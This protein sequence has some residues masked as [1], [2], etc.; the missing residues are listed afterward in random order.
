MKAYGNSKLTRR[1]MLKMLGMTAGGAAL[2]SCVPAPVP[3]ETAAE[4]AA[5]APTEVA[6]TQAPA[7]EPVTLSL[8]FGDYPEE[9]F[10]EAFDLFESQTS[11]KLDW[12]DVPE[13]WVKVPAA[14]AAGELPDIIPMGDTD[15]STLSVKNVLLPLSGYAADVDM[16][17]FIQSALSHSSWGGELYGMPYECGPSMWVYNKGLIQE[18]GVDDPWELAKKG[19][20][21]QSAFDATIQA[22]TKG[23]GDD[24]QW[25][26]FEPSKSIGI[27]APWVHGFGGQ[28]F[29]DD[30]SE[31]LLNSP[32]SLAAYEYILTQKWDG[33]AADPSDSVAGHTGILPL[34]NAGKVGFVY[35]PRGLWPA[36]NHDMELGLAPPF[37]FTVAGKPFTR[38]GVNLFSVRRDT[39]HPDESWE[40]VHFF[41]T[42]GNDIL[43]KNQS[44]TPNR[45]T[46]LEGSLWQETLQAEGGWEDPQAW[47]MGFEALIATLS[48]PGYYEIDSLVQAAYD[49]AY[50]KNQTIQE[51]FDQAIEAANQILAEQAG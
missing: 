2:A 7:A 1:Q 25:G 51:A 37:V 23:S 45:Q 30:F 24:A 14:A 40:F 8:W 17:D 41:A 48:P 3:P 36:L 12:L 19:E 4:P 28:E 32:E 31:C 22:L 15:V 39:Q 47:K 18:A 9:I 11:I 50:L 20:W 46:A 10:K 43:V 5:V 29:S 26:T 16:S 44:G 33:Y 35:F 38:H 49:S 6:A 21:T 34:F 13:Y 42:D 27:Q